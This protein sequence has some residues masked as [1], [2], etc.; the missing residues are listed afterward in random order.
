MKLK[1]CIIN[2]AVLTVLSLTAAALTGCGKDG[3]MLS[4]EELASVLSK[5]L[6]EKVEITDGPETEGEG[7]VYTMKSAGGTEFTVRRLRLLRREFGPYYYDYYCDYLINWVHD[8]P[9]LTAA[10]DKKG[11]AHDDIG[12]GTLVFAGNFDEVH[13]AVEAA[14][15]MAE[16]D[17]NL[18]PAVS[19]FSGEYDLRFERPKVIVYALNATNR[20]DGRQWLWGEY[21]YSDGTEKVDYDE[22]L[23]IFLN[24]RKYVDE[25]RKGDIDVSLP[26]NILEKYGPEK[27]KTELM[28]RDWDLQ[29]CILEIVTRILCTQAA[30]FLVKY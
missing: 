24:E 9:E 27:F 5:T 17:S 6:G 20:I 2:M 10:A 18:I 8:H 23:E 22:E 14:C 26:D 3:R 28:N 4:D 16:D 7:V 13:T 11:I 21:K 29:P 19:D 30:K 1:K 15:E 25:V 12:G